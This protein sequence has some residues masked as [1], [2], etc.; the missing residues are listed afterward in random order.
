VRRRE[1]ITLV[2]GTA[3][4]WP[5]AVSAQPHSPPIIG[6]LYQVGDD[7]GINPFVA[8]FHQGLREN[9][10]IEGRNIIVRER[11]AERADRLLRLAAELVSQQV[12]VI[13][14]SGSQAV[15]AA[16]Q[17]T[18]TIPVVMTSSSD[19]IGTGFVAS[20]AKPGGNI[21][22]L[23]MLT[24]DVSGKRLQLLKEIVPGLS[25]IAI[26]WNPD[27]PPAALS[28]KETQDLA[29]ALDISS[30]AVEVRNPDDF[31]AAFASIASMRPQAIV[32]LSAPIMSNY[33]GR[34]AELALKAMLP[35][36]QNNKV[37][38]KAGGLMSYGPNLSDLF[39]RA[40]TY[41]DKILK[42]AKPA[43]LPVEQPTK[44]ELVINLKTAKALGLTIPASVLATADEVIE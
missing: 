43:D 25:K 35:T 30:Q 21:T 9:G 14:A 11:P 8:A 26:L 36:V 2:G 1:F 28:L 13:V 39:R 15:Q 19:P 7:T 31:N 18:T 10:Y 44:F 42:G 40:A 37:F 29:A 23:S 5:L 12:D 38:A 34:L 41:V 32:L 17:A 3:A 6:F 20:L 27:D 33:A 16:K 22:G 4:G 24:T